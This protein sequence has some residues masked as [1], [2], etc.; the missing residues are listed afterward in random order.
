M[1]EPTHDI[2]GVPLP[3]TNW[4]LW[5]ASGVLARYRKFD[6]PAMAADVLYA[7]GSSCAMYTIAEFT[8]QGWADLMQRIESGQPTDKASVIG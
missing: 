4:A 2:N 1:S 8:D 7:F 3:R 5:D 6:E